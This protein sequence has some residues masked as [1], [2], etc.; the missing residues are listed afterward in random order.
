[1][2]KGLLS[3]LALALTVVGCQNYDD[4][5]DE[6]TSQITSLQSTVDG[7]TSVSSAIT[8]LQSTV[9]GLA[10]TLGA[11]QTTVDGITNYDDTG[12]VAQLNA[13]SSTLADLLAQLDGVATNADLAA[14]SDT[15]AD[16]QADVRELLE[17][18]S[19]INQN[20]TINNEATL[21]Y[22]ETLVSTDTEDP[23]VIVNGQVTVNTTNFS[24]SQVDRT[25]DIV[26]KLATVLDDVSVTSTHTLDFASL[27]FIDADLTIVGAAQGVGELRTISNDLT[28]TQI[29]AIDFSD[30]TSAD[31]VQVIAQEGTVTNVN[32]ITSVDFGTA[33]LG[34]LK[35]G[36]AGVAGNTIDTPKAGSIV[37]GNAPVIQING[38]SAT[39]IDHNYTGSAALAS[40]SIT[41]QP[42]SENGTVDVLVEEVTGGITITGTK[43]LVVKLNSLTSDNAFTMGTQI[44]QLHLSNVVNASGSIN[45]LVADLTSFRAHSAA[46]DIAVTTPNLPEVD[47]TTGTGVLTLSGDGAA[48]LKNMDA[49]LVAPDITSLTVT[50]LAGN[51]T[52]PN[53]LELQTLDISGKVETAAVPSTQTNVVVVSALASLTNLTLGGAFKTVTSAGNAKMASITTAGNIVNLTVTGAS[54][55]ATANIGH[56]HINGNDAA[57]LDFQG[58]ILP[59]LDL[60]SVSKVRALTVTGNAKLES[61]TAPSTTVLA[62]AGATVAITIGVNSM[63]AVWEQYVPG[64]P[65]TGTTPAIPAVPA[66]LKSNGLVSIQT[67]VNAYKNTQTASPTFS[68]DSFVVSGTTTY[69][70]FAAV[71]AAD[72]YVGTSSG[73]IDDYDELGLIA[74]E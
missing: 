45:A 63:T 17:G 6:L 68:I 69:A 4:Q 11:V 27:T 64:I 60:S 49:T 31:N 12:I 7:L 26:R 16:V 46:L 34:S 36:A 21:L 43:T 48:T 13:V 2:K 53:Y 54:K 25:N 51:V 38:D 70:N 23:N 14:I 10:S 71:T 19:T 28:V 55:L 40:L 67:L 9:T 32:S 5:F 35:I 33:T 29:G 39:D 61:L 22:A 3:L 56:D 1:M 62:E 73:T 20:V 50:E 65:A 66:K 24:Q 42:N 44:G 8:S 58:T 15:L 59:S 30:L 37:T 74:A 57:S 52:F 41:A 47:T 18:E 72:A